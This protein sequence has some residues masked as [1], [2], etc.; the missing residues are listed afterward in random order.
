MDPGLEIVSLYQLRSE[1]CVWR[2]CLECGHETECFMTAAK[3]S[4][5]D[6]CSEICSECQKLVALGERVFRPLD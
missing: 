1:L 4:R 2:R 3:H 5:T 6:D